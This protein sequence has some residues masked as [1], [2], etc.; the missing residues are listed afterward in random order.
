MYV[1]KVVPIWV[2]WRFGGHRLNE[3]L[4]Y[5]IVTNCNNLSDRSFWENTIHKL[6]HYDPCYDLYNKLERISPIAFLF[7]SLIQ[8]RSPRCG[9]DPPILMS[10]LLH[11]KSSFNVA[12]KRGAIILSAGL[13]THKCKSSAL[14]RT[15]SIDLCII[16][17]RSAGLCVTRRPTRVPACWLRSAYVSCD[18]PQ[19]VCW[20]RSL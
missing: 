8:F 12:P 6:Y 10:N 3:C 9:T 14:R 2:N 18:P 1:M 16:I 4:R 15:L 5:L 19:N 20:P 11:N 17:E 7:I 13:I